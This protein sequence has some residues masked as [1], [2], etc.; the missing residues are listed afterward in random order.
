[1]LVCME[2]LLVLVLLC[3]VGALVVLALAWRRA[4]RPAAAPARPRGAAAAAPCPEPA[5]A[6]AVEP[7]TAAGPPAALPTAPAAPPTPEPG[8]ER[9]KH[10]RLRTDQ[11]F[12]VT[13]F[14]GREMMAQCRDVSLGGMRFGVVGHALREGDLVRVTFNVGEETVG[15]IG[16]VLRSRKL[17]PITTDVS[18]EFVRLDPWAARLLE[19]ALEADV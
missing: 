18:L 17:D 15:A 6:P 9:R 19:E 13:P 12:S 14:A 4:A 2:P 7:L 8:P 16:R 10:V 1:M 5:A 11:T 3:G